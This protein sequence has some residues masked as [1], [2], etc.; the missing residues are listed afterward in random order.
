MIIQCEAGDVG[1]QVAPDVG[2]ATLTTV[3][4]RKATPEPSTATPRTQRPR[5]PEPD[6]V[7]AHHARHCSYPPP[8]LDSG[9]VSAGSAGGW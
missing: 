8:T 2:S 6:F 1:V 7:P 3:P 9:R 5:A 4:S